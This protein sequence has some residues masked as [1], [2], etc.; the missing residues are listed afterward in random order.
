[1]VVVYQDV[2]LGEE[3]VVLRLEVEAP[4]VQDVAA[5]DDV[6]QMRTGRHKQGGEV[7]VERAEA[8]TQLLP[9]G[10][11]APACVA[12]IVAAPTT[13]LRCGGIRRG[14]D[15]FNRSAGREG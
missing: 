11:P 2:G 1:V 4:E 3:V 15:A 14:H 8:P 12:Q 6:R 13:G 9:H 5:R 10:L 7:L